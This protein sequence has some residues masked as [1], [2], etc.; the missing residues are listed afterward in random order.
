MS[1]TSLTCLLHDDGNVSMIP[2]VGI[3][4]MDKTTLAQIVYN[5]QMVNSNFHHRVWVCVSEDF[6]VKRLAKEIFK[7]HSMSFT[8]LIHASCSE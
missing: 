3:G 4:G 6:N 7:C 1:L 5:D 2:I 8:C